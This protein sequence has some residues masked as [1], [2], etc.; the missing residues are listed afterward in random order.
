MKNNDARIYLAA[1]F[2]AIA[3]LV[4]TQARA[5][6][7]AGLIGLQLPNTTITLAQ[8][9]PA[10]TF[11]APNGQQ[12]QNMPAFCEVQGISK[13][14]SVSAINFEVWLP[15]PSGWNG[16]FEGVGNGGLAGTISYS[17]MAPGLQR[18][19]ASASTDTGHN[20]T[21][22]QLWL[23][24]QDLVIDY[25]YRGLHLTTVNAKAIIA[26]FYNRAPRFSYYSGCSTGGKQALFE[27]QR[28]P[29][30]Y[31]GIIGGD[32]ANF[33]THQM[34]H[35]DWVGQAT[36]TPAT[37]LSADNLQ[38][39]NNAVL[40][41]CSS[42]DHGLASDPFLLDPQDCHFDPRVLL[43]TGGQSTNCL[44]AE[45]VGAVQTIYQGVTNPRTEVQLY[46]GLP[47]GSELGWG[48]AGGQF[49]INRPVSEGSGVSSYDFF[50]FTVFQIPSPY[51]WDYTTLNFD[52]DVT[53]VDENFS[54]L[55]NST[56]PDLSAF[57]RHGGKLIMYH[58]NADPLIPPANTINY[59]QSEA[60]TKPS[61][62][63]THSTA[64][65][66][67]ETQRFFR[68]FLVPGM[69]HCAGGPGAN[70]FN[71][72]SNQGN[73][74][75]PDHDILSALDLWVTS[76]QAPDQIIASNQTNGSVNFTRPLCP[77]PQNARYKGTGSTSDA[78]NFVCSQDDD[79]LPTNFDEALRLS[80]A[81]IGK[82]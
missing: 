39:L 55:F 19:F 77:Y 29:D 17:S 38:L 12:F 80:G 68:L 52:S 81:L 32:A 79:D 10:G 27:A 15:L 61:Y 46:P 56:N 66:I 8:L 36:V 33:W 78:A 48:P 53:L 64:L 30:D 13:P 60:S 50:R 6:T 62:R 42:K 26:A 57:K 54:S 51:F 9:Q 82:P 3:L 2:L 37:N 28:Y 75:D 18:G 59:Y 7:C 25:S 74:T 76:H 20:S 23:E 21:E 5:A 41:Q 4:P 14:T 49:L 24:N 58:G 72:V 69:Y 45:Q 34:F 71:G 40:Q 35:E 47:R 16:K 67:S 44:T 43:C 11:T 70:I 63:L 73:P 22:P 65:A 31:D 1:T